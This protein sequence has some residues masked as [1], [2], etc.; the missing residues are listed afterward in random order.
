MYSNVICWE[1]FRVFSYL[2]RF[3]CDLFDCLGVERDD[4]LKF[5]VVLGFR[6]FYENEYLGFFLGF[7][8]DE[9]EIGINGTYSE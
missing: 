9:Y 4:V 6:F 5:C 3:E 1:I 2:R 8:N 7:E